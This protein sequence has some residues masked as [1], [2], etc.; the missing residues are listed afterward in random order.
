LAVPR[1]R[2][3]RSEQRSDTCRAHGVMGPAPGSP[4]P[5]ERL[6][7]RDHIGRHGSL[8]L[9][10]IALRCQEGALRHELTGEAG[11]KPCPCQ[12]Q[13]LLLRVNI[14]LGDGEPLLK[15]AHLD[16]IAGDFGEQ[17]DEGIAQAFLGCGNAGVCSLDGPPYTA[18]EV[19]LPTGIEAGLE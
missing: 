19:D 9:C 7:E 18:E 14:L 3:S 10:Q 17:G 11:V 13:G 1:H 16:I 8:A 2:P 6:V 5:P 12:R 15:A 4:G